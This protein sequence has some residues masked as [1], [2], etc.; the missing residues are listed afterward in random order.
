MCFHSLLCVQQKWWKIYCSES[1][2]NVCLP[3]LLFYFS[4][5]DLHVLIQNLTHLF[6]YIY[7]SHYIFNPTL[8]SWRGC[9]T[10]SIFKWSKASLNSVFSF[11]STG[12]CTKAKKNQSTLLFTYHGNRFML[13]PKGISMKGN[14]TSLIQNLDSDYWFQFLLW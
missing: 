9:D 7:F 3:A 8:P 4:L 13:F 10:R 14:T 5:F 12:C 11:S 1:P 2:E 6:L